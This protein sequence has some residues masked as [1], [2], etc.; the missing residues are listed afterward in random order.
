M[1]KI[2]TI[3]AIS[4]LFILL[5]TSIGYSQN[6]ALKLSGGMD[7]LVVKPAESTYEISNYSFF[8]TI[9]SLFNDGGFGF[10][11]QIVPFINFHYHLSYFREFS[12]T[13]Y[14]APGFIVTAGFN[15][16][17]GLPGIGGK[18]GGLFSV[19]PAE[20]VRLGLQVMVAL[21]Y[22]RTYRD[23]MIETKTIISI[24]LT[25]FFMYGF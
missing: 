22:A 12:V 7:F 13:E 16:A 5:F 6:F 11:F 21:S 18:I 19:T 2:I 17:N 4:F 14:L 3:L 10:E 23:E 9:Y 20:S 25:I 24:P 8:I 15:Y 1:K